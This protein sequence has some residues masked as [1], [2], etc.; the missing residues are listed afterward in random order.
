MEERKNDES[1]APTAFLWSAYLPHRYLYEV[2][3]CR[4]LIPRCR[5]MARK[6]RRAPGHGRKVYIWQFEFSLQ[7][8]PD[9]NV[10]D[11][12]NLRSN[13]V[14]FVRLYRHCSTMNIPFA[15]CCVPVFVVAK[16]L[17]VDDDGS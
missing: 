5:F 9:L 14:E 17:V 3:Q 6:A 16:D 12:R 7:R 13:L 10:V 2:L 1:V 11:T 15:R 4:F 8:A